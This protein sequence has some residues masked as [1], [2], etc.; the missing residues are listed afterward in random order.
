MHTMKQKQFIN[1]DLSKLSITYTKRF[2][3]IDL[4]TPKI[5]NFL[6]LGN[7]F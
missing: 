7:L 5:I 3:M 2:L 4:F 6:S 1:I